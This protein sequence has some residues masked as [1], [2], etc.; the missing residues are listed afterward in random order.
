M[1]ALLRRLLRLDRSEAVVERRV[2]LVVLAADEPVERLEATPA[3]RPRIERPDGRRLPRRHLVTL[4]ELRRRVAVQLQRRRQRSLRVRTHP[5]RPR[6]RRR[7]LSDHPHPDRVMIAAREQR[8]S[9]RRTQRGRVEP[10]VG[11]PA[12]LQALGDRHLRR[13]AERARGA[14]PDIVEQDHENVRSALRR[15]QRLDRRKRRIRILRVI[16]RQPHMLPLR[17]RK[18]GARKLG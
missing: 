14:E 18:H 8:R 17:N 7:G 10:S 6:S 11:E 5:A 3:R 13:P 1:V 4:A 9:G 16:R 12:G 2:V 15:Q